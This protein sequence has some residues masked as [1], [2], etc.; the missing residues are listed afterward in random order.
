MSLEQP[1]ASCVS[2]APASKVHV[3][4]ILLLLN[5]EK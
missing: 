4:A 5:V 3:S 2:A 1:A